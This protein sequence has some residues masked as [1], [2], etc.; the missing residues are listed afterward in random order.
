MMMMMVIITIA[1]AIAI[2]IISASPTTII[3]THLLR[4]EIQITRRMNRIHFWSSCCLALA[5]SMDVRLGYSLAKSACVVPQEWQRAQESISH[6]FCLY[7]REKRFFYHSLIAGPC[8]SRH[9]H[10]EGTQFEA[11]PSWQS[12]FAKSKTNR[13]NSTIGTK[14]RMVACLS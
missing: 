5:R 9:T 2:I 7:L 3:W 1:I 4:S 12:S 8:F 14:K 11:N 13:H 6:H 10:L